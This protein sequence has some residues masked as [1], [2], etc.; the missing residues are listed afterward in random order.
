M[1]RHGCTVISWLVV[2]FDRRIYD[3]YYIHISEYDVQYIQVNEYEKT[4]PY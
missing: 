3:A 2:T 1:F 4:T